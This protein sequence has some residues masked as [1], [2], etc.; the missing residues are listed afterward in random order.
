M[1]LVAFFQFGHQLSGVRDI[2]VVAI[3]YFSNW[4]YQY[5]TANQAVEQPHKWGVL[6]GSKM[7][8][9]HA[10]KD[11]ESSGGFPQ[12]RAV[13]RGRHFGFDGAGVSGSQLDRIMIR[14]AV[15]S[16]CT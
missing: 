12:H 15:S 14:V 6:G 5:D 9:P 13:V 7:T 1:L 10:E 3:V 8:P 2:W 11:A 4:N 16:V